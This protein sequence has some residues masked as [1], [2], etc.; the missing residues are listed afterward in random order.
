[1]SL[2]TT[3]FDSAQY[4]DSDEAITA[5]LD[6]ALETDDPAFSAQALGTVARAR[7]MSQISKQ[8]ELSR[9]SLYNALSAEGNP[10]CA[11][12]RGG[13]QRRRGGVTFIPAARRASCQPRGVVQRFRT[14]NHIADQ[15]WR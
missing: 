2:K 1:M 6:E 9:E 8:T 10:E 14:S 7:G 4:L 12:R 3:G 15:A 11:G 5:Y 13:D